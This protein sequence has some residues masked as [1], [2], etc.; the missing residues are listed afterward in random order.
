MAADQLSVDIVVP[1]MRP[2]SIDFTSLI[3]IKTPEGVLIHYIFVIDKPGFNA[4]VDFPLLHECPEKVTVVV[5]QQNIGA[6]A[7]RNAGLD[8]SKGDYVLFLDDD[9]IPDENLL[10]WYVRAIDKHPEDWGFV[11]VT[12]FPQPMNTFTAGVL[13]SDILTFFGISLTRERLSWGTTSNIM[14]KRSVLKE[15]RFSVEFPKGGGG[16]DIDFCL[17]A[18]G[19]VSTLMVAVPEAEVTHHWWNY[20]KRSYRRF[21]RWA[22]GDSILP[23]IHKEFRYLNFPNLVETWFVMVPL[24]AMLAIAGLCSNQDVALFFV[25]SFSAD[26]IFEIARVKILK[27][28]SSLISAFESALVRLSNDAGR[29]A[30]NIVRGR[31]LFIGERFDYFTTGESKKFE[32]KMAAVKFTLLSAMAIVSIFLTSVV[33]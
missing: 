22:F 4:S 23:S 27:P 29:F 19:T 15:I 28:R 6:A 25:L 2:H 33:L 7:S 30:G 26:S 24:L 21:F 11:G 3:N 8:L 20:G 13:E 12:K 10:I 32:R 9:V 16:E 5:N 1:S 14:L 18:M 17:R 31:L